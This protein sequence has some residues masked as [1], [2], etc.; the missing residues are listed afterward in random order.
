VQGGSSSSPWW[1]A[2][3]K[4]KARGRFLIFPHAISP[5]NNLKTKTRCLENK[6]P[7][8]AIY[9]KKKYLKKAKEEL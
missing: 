4:L 8:L 3:T 9:I 1:R 2:L 7:G 6:T 5:E